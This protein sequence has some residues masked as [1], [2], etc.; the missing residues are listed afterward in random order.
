M[1]IHVSVSLGKFYE[2]ASFSEKKGEELIE[3]DI[4]RFIEYNKTHLARVYPKGTRTN[5]SNYSPLRYWSAG[6]QLGEYN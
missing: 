2:M 3:S 1:R 5:S 4:E 6:C